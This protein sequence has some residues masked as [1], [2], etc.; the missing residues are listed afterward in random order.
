MKTTTY[1]CDRCTKTSEAVNFTKKVI[2][3]IQSCGYIGMAV[4]IYEGARTDLKVDWCDD[5]CTAVGI[6]IPLPEQKV[7]SPPPTIDELITEIIEQ[8]VDEKIEERD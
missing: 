6:S 1:T 8:A 5:C 3:G 4:D 7:A 2:V